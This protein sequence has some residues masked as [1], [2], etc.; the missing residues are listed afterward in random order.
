VHAVPTEAKSQKPEGINV[1]E[2]ELQMVVNHHVDAG[3]QT[4]V[5]WKSGQGS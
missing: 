2:V 1:L 4:L 3:N 5:L